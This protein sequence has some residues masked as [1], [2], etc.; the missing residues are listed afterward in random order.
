MIESKSRT[1]QI[2]LLY[3]DISNDTYYQFFRTFSADRRRKSYKFDFCSRL[4]V[5]Q[6]LINS[7]Y[8]KSVLDTDTDTGTDITEE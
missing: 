6:V 5:K 1:L 7:A 2:D 8:L 3:R 4:L